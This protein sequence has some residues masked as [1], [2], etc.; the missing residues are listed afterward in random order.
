LLAVND[1]VDASGGTLM[2]LATRYWLISIGTT[3]VRI[4]AVER[5][6]EDALADLTTLLHLS[7]QQ[8]W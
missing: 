2:S 5:E 8:P 1:L 3:G 4:P 7:R 6:V